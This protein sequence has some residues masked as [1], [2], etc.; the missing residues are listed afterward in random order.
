MATQSTE[1]T[2]TTEATAPTGD[3][4]IFVDAFN[5]EIDKELKSLLDAKA[6]CKNTYADAIKI[7][8]PKLGDWPNDPKVVTIGDLFK[9][10]FPDLD[11]PRSNA[12]SDSDPNKGAWKKDLKD[13]KDETIKQMY[14]TI[15]NGIRANSLIAEYES[16]KKPGVTN[17][18]L[19]SPGQYYF[20]VFMS[21]I[22]SNRGPLK[23]PTDGNGGDNVDYDFLKTYGG[24]SSVSNFDPSGE[25]EL[26]KHG[27]SFSSYPIAFDY[28]EFSN[29]ISSGYVGQSTKSKMIAITGI[30]LNLE[31]DNTSAPK[32][33]ISLG[34]QYKS[35]ITAELE[36]DPKFNKERGTA[37]EAGFAE[38]WGPPGNF[39]GNYENILLYKAFVQAGDNYK[40]VVLPYRNPEPVVPIV[41][42]EPVPIAVTPT[43]LE[44]EYVFNVEKIDTFIFVSGTPS[45]PIEFTI[46]PNDGTTYI[47][48][49]TVNDTNYEIGDDELSDEY[50]EGG[51]Q[52]LE[53]EA[54]D[55]R[56]ASGE[57]KANVESKLDDSISGETTQTGGTAEKNLTVAEAIIKVMNILINEGGFSVK[58]AAGICGN[59]KA[60]SGFKFWNIEDGASNIRPGGMGS[61]RWD[62][63]KA[64]GQNYAGKRFS[65]TGLAQWTYGRRYNYEKY[66]GEWLTKKGVTT[67]AL[68]NGFFDTDPGLHSSEYGKV[69]GGA[70]D[71]LEAYLKTVPYLFDAACSFL[72]HE[73]KT[74]YSGIVN[75]MRGSSP[76]GNAGTLI[77]NGFF[78]NK[79]GG[80]VSQTVEGFAE[81]VVCNFEVPG[82]VGKARNGEGKESYNKLVAERTKLARDCYTTYTNSNS[83]NV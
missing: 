39:F 1:T 61:N 10:T 74:S 36:K 26:E 46:V 52:G 27:G 30:D 7:T 17:P 68:K 51:Y 66:V 59:I 73:L 45:I 29:I 13:S 62:S 40:S 4:K 56:S 2:T 80:K 32:S 25:I 35:G 81:L 70:G 58:E 82:P 55:L 48:E 42:Q 37:V 19:Y 12:P 33:F 24:S 16:I 53:E 63:G 3:I 64:T 38:S 67:K 14:K 28:Y 57:Q 18:S 44:S 60:E 8:T 23:D 15:S 6:N 22:L 75:I 71:K 72:Q 76:S 20:D 9:F 69:Y 31:P 83:K 11:S 78:V 43:P 65:G 79:S 5:I 47:F 21:V 50:S 34:T 49:E 41:P 77:K 54:A